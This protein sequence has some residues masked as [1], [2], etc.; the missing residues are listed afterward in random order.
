MFT[1]ITIHVFESPE[2]ISLGFFCGV[3]GGWMKSKVYKTKVDTPDEFLARILD[4]VARIKKRE[5]QLK[6]HAIFAHE[7]QSSLRLTVGFSNNYY[8]M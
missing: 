2:L 1:E 3:G 7:L 5:D 6:Q 8:E 4:A